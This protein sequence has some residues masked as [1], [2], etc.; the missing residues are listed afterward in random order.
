MRLRLIGV[1]LTISNGGFFWQ[2]CGKFIEMRMDEYTEVNKVLI[3]FPENWY[4]VLK[5]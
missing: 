2:K 1:N 5:K 4:D 3:G